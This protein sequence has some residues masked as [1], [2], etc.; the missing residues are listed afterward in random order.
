MQQREESTTPS[1]RLNES[2][3]LG[4][5]F[6]QE[7]LALHDQVNQV[8]QTVTVLLQFGRNLIDFPAVAGF[9]QATGGVGQHLLGQAV[10][11]L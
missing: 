6:I 1:I 4:M 10:S 9:E 3:P 5:L 7:D 2:S 11:D 8:P